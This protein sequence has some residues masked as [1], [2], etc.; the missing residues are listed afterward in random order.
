MDL[1]ELPISPAVYELKLFAQLILGAGK[2]QTDVDD[3]KVV[4]SVSAHLVSDA[5]QELNCSINVMAVNL[6]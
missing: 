4:G 6:Q 1:S 2:V 5:A 3:W